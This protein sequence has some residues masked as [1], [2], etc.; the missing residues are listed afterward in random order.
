M[1]FH[2]YRNECQEYNNIAIFQLE[3][4]IKILF[5]YFS[6]LKIWE[7]FRSNFVEL[8]AYRF[9]EFEQFLNRSRKF[10]ILK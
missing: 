10:K 3:K 7:R 6:L 5:N 2:E 8:K 9:F 1:D 4:L